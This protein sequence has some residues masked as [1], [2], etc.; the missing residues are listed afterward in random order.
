MASYIERLELAF[1]RKEIKSIVTE[2]ASD[3]RVSNA[4]FELIVSTADDM[5]R[6]VRK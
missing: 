4:E 5:E 6:R 3:E 2:A 1:S